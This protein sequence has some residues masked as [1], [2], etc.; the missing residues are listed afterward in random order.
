[1]RD[2]GGD[3]YFFFFVLY[4]ALLHLPPLRFHCADGCWDRTQDRCNWCIGSQTPT[5]LDLIRVR[6]GFRIQFR[7]DICPGHFSC[8][9]FFSGCY[10]C[11]PPL[12]GCIKAW[13]CWLRDGPLLR[14]KGQQGVRERWGLQMRGEKVRKRGRNNYIWAVVGGG[15]EQGAWRK[16]SIE[17][18][19]YLLSRLLVFLLSVWP[20]EALFIFANKGGCQF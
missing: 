12:Y 9:L 5:R 10:S 16:E 7:N 15:G 20:V 19:G 8:L 13:E 6:D 1:M 11:P 17:Y 18:H 14:R 3:Y 2:G 4:S